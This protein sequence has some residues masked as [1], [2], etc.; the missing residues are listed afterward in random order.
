M[1]F[2]DSGNLDEI[3]KYNNFGI[4]SGVTTNP[5][6][7]KKDGIKD[8]EEFVKK[9]REF[10]SGHLSLEVTSNDKEE[11]IKEALYLNTLS[12]NI[13]V[14][15]PIHGPEGE[16]HYLE[17]IKR[18]KWEL[19]LNITALMSISQCIVASLAVPMCKSY[20]SLFGGRVNNM[21]Y[22]SN[23]EIRKIR[24]F[25]DSLS[26]GQRPKL[27]IGSTREVLNISEWL[28]SGADIVTVTPNLIN[29]MIVHPYTKETVQM[30]LR[31]AN[32]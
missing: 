27:I 22:D 23:E 32:G 11:M 6:I 5:T 7:L 17:V 3:Q 13:S 12:S 28:L 29:Q 25:L 20:I 16:L 18:L 15:I 19:S 4:I 21:G 26:K 8:V 9:L 2:L 24:Q 31:D 14:K 30:F 10:F 1:L